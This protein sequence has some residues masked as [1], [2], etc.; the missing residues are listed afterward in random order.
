MNKFVMLGLLPVT[1]LSQTTMQQKPNILVV[2]S[3]DQSVPHAGCYG[4]KDIKTPHLD[5]FAK[6]GMVFWRAYVTSPQ[7]S[8]SRASI[9]TGRSPVATMMTRFGAPLD[10]SVVTYPEYLIKEA[11]YYAGLCGRTHHLNGHGPYAHAIS[12][13]HNL[14]TAESRMQYVKIA[15]P[16]AEGG[17]DKALDQFYEFMETRD[18][19][20]PF[21]LQFSFF[22]P[23]R[24]YT[25]P[26]VHNPD[27][28]ALP[29]QFPDTK[30][31]REALA[32]YYDEI[33]R[34]D[35]DFGKVLAYLDKNGLRD[36]T[37][38]IFLGDNGASLFRGKGTL[39]E[40]GVNVPLIISW[41]GVVKPGGVSH[42]LI[43][44]EDLAPTML[45]AAG[46][47]P[48]PDMTGISFMSIL[49]GNPVPTRKYAFAVRGPHDGLPSAFNG[50]FDQARV[51][52]SKDY[53]LIYNSQP[54]LRFAPVGFAELPF[55]K[56]IITMN[57]KGL[58]DEKFVNFYF[59]QTPRPLLELY[60]LKN[61]PF[62]TKN[63]ALEA[64]YFDVKEMLLKELIVWMILERDHLYLPFELLENK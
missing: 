22:D 53:K 4:N 17:Q 35:N 33:H 45:E 2:I 61:D 21:Y 55:Y 29:Y 27:A 38:V 57:E 7:S 30:G 3:D 44:M 64:T 23:H 50:G 58:L 36:N 9:L 31:V 34:A 54:T 63:V 10:K 12:V 26:K 41:P 40:Y 15:E 52:I 51:I 11:G 60:D 56:E 25:A 32:A 8:P 14:L 59:Y 49:K 37:I 24:P 46:L 5:Q 6:E 19:D 42:E 62:E 1:A 16:D 48:K 39:Y 18:K 43:S 13:E 47:T 20:K 28:L